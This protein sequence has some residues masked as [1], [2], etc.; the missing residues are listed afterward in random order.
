M[1]TSELSANLTLGYFRVAR[2]PPRIDAKCEISF[3]KP[4]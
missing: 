3:C 4:T 1:N 2:N